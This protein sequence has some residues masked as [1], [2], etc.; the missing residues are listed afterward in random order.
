MTMAR[1]WATG[2]CP[3]AFA[4]D[5]PNHGPRPALAHTDLVVLHSISLPPGVY[6]GAEV[7]ALFT[8]VLDW[9]AHP[10]FQGIRGL[11]VSAHFYVQR[12]GTLWQFVSCQRRAWHAGVSHYRGRDNC[13]DDSIGIELEGLEGSTFTP[14]QYQ[15]LARLLPALCQHH[16]IAYLAGHEH[17]APGRKH[18]PGAGFDWPRLQRE[19]A[20]PE[21]LF[22]AGTL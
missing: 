1:D 11:R 7:H 22:A 8:N 4:V 2:W 9:D 19:S 18:D 20:L 14:A 3:H 10:Y 21:H 5:S 13:N 17:I 6:G 16:P 12:N 15:C